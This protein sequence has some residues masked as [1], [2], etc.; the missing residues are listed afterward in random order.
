[1]L[2]VLDTTFSLILIHLI[3]IFLTYLSLKYLE[4]GLYFKH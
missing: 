1:M 4:H 3:I 2:I